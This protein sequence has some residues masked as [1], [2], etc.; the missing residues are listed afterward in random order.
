MGFIIQPSA[1]WKPGGLEAVAILDAAPEFVFLG[2][3]H[4]VS[5]ELE[6][7]HKLPALWEGHPSNGHRDGPPAGRRRV[8]HDGPKS[9]ATPCHA[10]MLVLPCNASFGFVTA[11]GIK[12]FCRSRFQS[13]FGH[14]SRHFPLGNHQLRHEF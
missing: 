1:V 11:R 5:K 10:P 12:L 2:V 4:G 9:M 13:T 3:R 8:R 6:D 7:G 14:S